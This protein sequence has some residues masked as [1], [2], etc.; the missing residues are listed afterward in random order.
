MYTTKACVLIPS[1]IDR[2]EYLISYCLKNYY[3]KHANFVADG[4]YVPE[5]YHNNCVDKEKGKTKLVTLGTYDC[6]HYGRINDL[7]EKLS[8]MTD[9]RDYYLD[10]TNNLENKLNNAISPTK[11][12]CAKQYSVKLEEKLYDLQNKLATIKRIADNG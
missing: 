4:K 3:V 7:E 8:A 5:W 12:E 6:G 1:E 9:A 11:H 10:K 2:L